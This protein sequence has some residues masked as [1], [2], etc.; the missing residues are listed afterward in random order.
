MNG[1]LD[2]K[3]ILHK[4]EA[5]EHLDTALEITED[6]N[7]AIHNR[8]EAEQYLQEQG[9]IVVRNRD[10]YGLIGIHYNKKEECLHLTK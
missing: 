9:W 3:G 2:P 8:L 10:V 6:M 7:P 5:W 1:F 4:C